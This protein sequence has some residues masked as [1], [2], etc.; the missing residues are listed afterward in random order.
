[1]HLNIVINTLIFDKIKTIPY[2][3]I[4]LGSSFRRQTK[5]GAPTKVE[6]GTA[7]VENYYMKTSRLLMKSGKI[8]SINIYIDYGINQKSINIYNNGE[9]FDFDFNQND[10]NVA[11]N[12][13][14]Y[15]GK[16]LKKI[17]RDYKVELPSVE[18]ASKSKTPEKE[19]K[20]SDPT[21]LINDPGSVSWEDL[22]KY[23][24]QQ[25]QNK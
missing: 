13:Q 25:K 16:L 10:F 6:F 12:M 18:N 8:G 19:E 20:Y 3:E 9:L 23:L 22:Q 11:G 5:R 21:K 7:F 2:F 15:I 4:D 17:E 1:M 24:N 14:K